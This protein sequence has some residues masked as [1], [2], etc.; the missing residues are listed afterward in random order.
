MSFP[1]RVLFCF[2]FSLY[3]FLRYFYPVTSFSCTATE[4][5]SK[6]INI[7]Q[8]F[9]SSSNIFW[10][11]SSRSEKGIRT[12]SFQTERRPARKLGDIQRSRLSLT[13]SSP[14]A[15]ISSV[16]ESLGPQLCQQWCSDTRLFFSNTNSGFIQNFCERAGMPHWI[17]SKLHMQDPPF[18]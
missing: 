18:I 4:R 1:C 3:S 13:L 15:K 11:S 6:I 14:T 8:F 7:L 10:T 9:N 17:M 2:K 16:Q 5:R 12:K